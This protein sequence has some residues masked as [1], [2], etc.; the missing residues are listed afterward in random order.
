MWFSLFIYFLSFVLIYHHNRV[1]IHDCS[2]V[3]WV[4]VQ[5]KS[6]GSAD[7]GIVIISVLSL[8]IAVM[9]T[10][11]TCKCVVGLGTG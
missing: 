10:Y 1:Y 2:G 11:M 9:T 3:L 6:C 5:A 4:E 8:T 7:L